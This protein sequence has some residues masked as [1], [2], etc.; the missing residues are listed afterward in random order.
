M[1]LCIGN[2]VALSPVVRGYARFVV[3]STPCEMFT[4]G[5]R[6]VLA[7]KGAERVI[8]RLESNRQKF[9]KHHVKGAL[10]QS[11]LTGCPCREATDCPMIHVTNEGWA[12]RRLWKKPKKVKKN[13]RHKE[14]KVRLTEN[15]VEWRRFPGVFVQ[16]KNPEKQR[17]L[18]KLELEV[19]SQSDCDTD[20]ASVVSGELLL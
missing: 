18:Q 5:I 7:T 20:D 15:T 1:Q 17:R 9:Y 11:V 13:R 3:V 19:A 6:F 14:P 16:H 10:C 4:V 2:Q 8:G 12:H